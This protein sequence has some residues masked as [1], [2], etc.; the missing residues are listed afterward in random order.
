MKLTPREMPAGSWE[1]ELQSPPLTALLTLA[2]FESSHAFT[3]AA[4]ASAGKSILVGVMG[5]KLKVAALLVCVLSAGWWWTRRDAAGPS[6]ELVNAGDKLAA[7]ELATLSPT[8][9]ETTL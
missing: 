3:M 2:G 5:T 8:S 7:A 1:F 9:G 6:R 4:S